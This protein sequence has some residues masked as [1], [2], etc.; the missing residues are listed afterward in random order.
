MTLR[1]NI[2]T[3]L[4]PTPRSASARILQY[5]V[6]TAL[7]V[8]GTALEPFLGADGRNYLL[9]GFMALSPSFIFSPWIPKTHF[10]L[11][12]FLASIA[13]FPLI[14]NPE[15]LRWSTILF[16]MMF[17]L[18]FVAYE[19]VLRRSKLD[20]ESFTRAI[21]FLLLAYCVVYVAQQ[22]AVLTG[23]P[24]LNES[25][26][27]AQ[28]KWKLNALAGEPSHAARIISM[29]M[30]AY[31]ALHEIRTGSTYS[32]KLMLRRDRLLWIGY[33]WLVTTMQSTTA[34]VFL[35][36]IL[37][38]LADR[39]NFVVVV[40][41]LSLTVSL[42]PLNVG[43]Q[44]DR[45]FTIVNAAISFDYRVLIAAD[46]SGSLRVAPLFVLAEMID[47]TSLQGWFG[48]GIDTVSSFMSDYIT[49]VE[50]GY[51]GGGML[52]VWYEYGFI[53]FALFITFTL[54]VGGALRSVSNFLFW[55]LIVFIAGPNNQI[56]WMYLILFASVNYFQRL[57]AGSQRTRTG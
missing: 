54:W 20:I 2:D 15:Y 37:L 42:L 50:F 17:A 35:P 41:A 43:E 56:V 31:L 24:I 27:N 23:L 12:L 22:V 51:T 55:L 8:F 18:S 34:L 57:G 4:Y 44:S 9:I 10:I 32:L 21:R 33:I 6:L 45:L 11:Y 16:S 30:F 48:H 36:I 13:L 5:Y 38:K 40:I 53:S 26:Y 52:L 28:Y 29:L 39:R 47:L 7:C 14:V 3:G 49:G 1:Q 19:N 25:N 46:H